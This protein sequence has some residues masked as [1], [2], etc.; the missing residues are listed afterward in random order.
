MGILY[1]KCHTQI[2]ECL[3]VQVLTLMGQVPTNNKYSWVLD[4][5]TSTYEY[6]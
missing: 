1:L 4:K 3:Y 6:L 2:H 5:L